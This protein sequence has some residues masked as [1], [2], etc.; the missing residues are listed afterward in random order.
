MTRFADLDREAYRIAATLNDQQTATLLDVR[1]YPRLAA[2]QYVAI[3]RVP[4]GLI[5]FEASS[6]FH[7]IMGLA[8]VSL[9]ELGEGVAEAWE[10]T[11]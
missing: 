1:N 10:E 2:G 11:H 4:S 3:E 6:M 8:R 7:A 9:T 5:T